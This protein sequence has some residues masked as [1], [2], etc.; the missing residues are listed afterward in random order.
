MIRRV[1][2]ADRVEGPAGIGAPAPLRVRRKFDDAQ[3]GARLG[4]SSF[5]GRPAASALPSLLA[6]DVVVSHRSVS[7]TPGIDS[8]SLILG[9]R[10]SVRKTD[11]PC[12][13]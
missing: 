11:R 4:G 1:A 12:A 9:A 6:G 7:A 10:P 13:L 2:G 5:T 3:N 8:I